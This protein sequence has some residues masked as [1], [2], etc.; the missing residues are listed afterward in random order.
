MKVKLAR[1]LVSKILPI[2]IMIAVMA[3]EPTDAG[4]A[5]PTISMRRNL[6]MFELWA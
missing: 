1:P 4:V 5:N 6:K 3:I 2:L